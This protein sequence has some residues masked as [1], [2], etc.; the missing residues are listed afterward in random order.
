CQLEKMNPD[1]Q[2]LLVNS[3]E[4]KSMCYTLNVHVLPLFRF[5]RG[6]QR[7]VCQFSCT[8]AT[9]KNFKDALAKYATDGCSLGPAKGLDE[10]ELSA[11]AANKDLS[12][13]YKP[14]PV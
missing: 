11:L 3:E 8:N 12:F 5:Y 6:A 2:F 1:L 14:K 10:K 13:T 9:I 4:H 7:R